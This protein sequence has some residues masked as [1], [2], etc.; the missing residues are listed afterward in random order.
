MP[1]IN[2]VIEGKY[3]DRKIRGG[4]TL[5][6]DIDWMPLNKRY[7]SSYTVIDESNKDQYSFWKGALGVALFGGIGAVAGIGGKNKKEYLIA[8]EWKDG[9]KSLILIND[10]YYKVFIKSMF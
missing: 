5:D 9:E 4:S 6:I 8:I 3:K 10:E 1:N 7:I 2:H